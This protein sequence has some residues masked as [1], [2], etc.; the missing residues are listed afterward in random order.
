MLHGRY[1]KAV[2][3]ARTLKFVSDERVVPYFARRLETGDYTLCFVA[4][5]ALGKFGSEE[6]FQAL[7]RGMR[8]QDKNLRH[9]AASS[10][11]QCPHPGAIPFLL[12]YRHDPSSGV[13]STIVSLLGKGTVPKSIA[14]LKT[15]LDE[16]EKA[17]R[18][19]IKNFIEELSKRKPK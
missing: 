5:T 11:A 3:A 12:T 14:L 19:D 15:M 6:A 8:F 18:D 16:S 4:L 1:D 7:K 13:R 2:E 9:V 17:Q 10:L